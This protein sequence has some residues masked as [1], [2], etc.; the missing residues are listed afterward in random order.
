MNAFPGR[1]AARIAYGTAASPGGGR[2]GV[3][4]GLA[5]EPLRL[6][7]AGLPIPAPGTIGAK[8]TIAEL[9]LATLKRL[10]DPWDQAALLL[11][12]RYFAFLAR[13]IE[14]DRAV[15]DA[16]LAPFDGLFNA[17]DFL[18]SAPAPLPRA[19]IEEAGGADLEDLQIPF[20]FWLGD[21]ITALLEHPSRLTPMRDRERATRLESAGVTIRHFSRAPP[22][23]GEDAYFAELLGPR[24]TRFFET[25]PV[26]CAPVSPAFAPL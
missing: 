25:E 24:L 7:N 3:A 17:Q 22:K 5:G 21:G 2:T 6:N 18:Y 9:L 12:D 15:I 20:V 8:G 14:R 4:I 13:S 26:P 19:R 11:L 10:C 1:A 16:N 23:A